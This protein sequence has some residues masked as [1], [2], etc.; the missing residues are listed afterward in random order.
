MIVYREYNIKPYKEVPTSY[1]ITTTGEGGS[2]PKALYGMFTSVSIC[3]K[4]IDDYLEE[5]EKANDKK[6]SKR[7]I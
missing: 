1:L 7:G 4:L 5:K 3:K 2:I 6:A